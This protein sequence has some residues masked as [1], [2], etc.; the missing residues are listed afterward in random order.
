ML[1]LLISFP[2]PIILALLINEIKNVKFKKFVQTASYLPHFLSWMAVIGMVQVIFGSQGL[3]NDIRLFFGATDRITPLA[4]QKNFIWFLSLLT[5]W[6]GVGWG[7]IVHLAGLAGINPELYEAAEVDGAKHLQKMW[8]ITLPHMLPTCVI[9]LIFRM[10]SVFGSN[11]Q[12]VYGLQN[13][14]IDFETISTIVY[15]TG[16]QN[17]NYSMASAIGFTEGIVSLILVVVTN[18]VA[19]KIT[20]SGIW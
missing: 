13:P 12:L 10:G 15:K 7:T 4:E 18:W 20:G 1:D 19:K 17:G 11:F 2:A 5:L 9:L 8:Y 6:K 3:F 14:F 16:I